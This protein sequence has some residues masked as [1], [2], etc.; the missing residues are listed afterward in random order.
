MEHIEELL[1]DM[2]L[3]LNALIYFQA[4]DMTLNVHSDTLYLL[5]SKGISCTGGYFFQQ[6]IL[7]DDE[8]IKLNRN[9]V[10]TCAIFK[11]VTASTVE[12]ELCALFI[13]AQ[14]ATILHLNLA[15]MNH[16]QTPTPVYIGASTCVGIVIGTVERQ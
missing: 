5:A 3:N 16:P 8:P 1:K 4:P 13:N 14:E 2:H 12:L 6:R 9:S 15:K 11:L 7:Q 10:T